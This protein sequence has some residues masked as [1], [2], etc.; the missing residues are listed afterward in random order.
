MLKYYNTVTGF[1][2]ILYNFAKKLTKFKAWLI[3]NYKT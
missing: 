3:K 1:M 2:I